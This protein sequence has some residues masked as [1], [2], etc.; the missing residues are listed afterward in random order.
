MHKNIIM[1]TQ[2]TSRPSIGIV[3]SVPLERLASRN[4]SSEF[5]P[6]N[7]GICRTV[8]EA[9]RNLIKSKTLLNNWSLKVQRAYDFNQRRQIMPFDTL[10]DV[11]VS[12]RPLLTVHHKQLQQCLELGIF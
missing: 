7:H 9:Y 1:N 5:T 11:D 8:E 4:N 3:S 10:S 6:W 12:V 2:S